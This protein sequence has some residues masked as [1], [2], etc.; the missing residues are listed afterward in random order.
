MKN[1]I[2]YFTWRRTLMLPVLCV[3]LLSQVLPTMGAFSNGQAVAARIGIASTVLLFGLAIWDWIKSA[4]EA[5][6]LAELIRH[7]RSHERRI[8]YLEDLER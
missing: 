4:G 1:L 2:D 8:S 7:V 3:V 5:Q 6:D